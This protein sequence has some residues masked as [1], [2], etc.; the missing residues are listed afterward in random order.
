MPIKQELEEQRLDA[1][2]RKNQAKLNANANG[3]A[4]WNG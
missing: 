2:G 4:Y 1:A 3:K